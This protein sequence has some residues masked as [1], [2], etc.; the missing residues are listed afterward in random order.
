MGFRGCVN[1]NLT[2]G[3][4]GPCHAYLLGGRE[5]EGLRHLMTLM[6][7]ARISTGIYAL[8]LASSAYLNA[9]AYARGRVQ[10]K[11][12]TQSLN[13]RAPSV[14][15]LEHA[16][17][18]RMLLTMKSAV[19]GCRSLVAL[20]G[21][22]EAAL[23]LA[24]A[25]PDPASAPRAQRYKGLIDM[26]TPIVKAYCSDQAW[27]ICELAIQVY[28]GNGYLRDHYVERCARDVKVLSIWEGTN[29]I[30]SQFLIRDG[31]GWVL[32]LRSIELSAKKSTNS[33]RAPQDLI[34]R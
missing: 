25:E 6:S 34:K 8:G 32:N 29:Y 19:E 12:Y 15:I 21:D 10:G 24:Q 3:A 7:Q 26:L 30:Q 9:V 33:S 11:S 1:A 27:R 13:G 4:D 22:Y 31:L 23:L 5:N 16:D 20:L 18:Q 2:F 28:G 17:V 14:P